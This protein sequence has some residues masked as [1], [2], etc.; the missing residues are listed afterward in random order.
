MASFHNLLSRELALFSVHFEHSL[1]LW[2]QQSFSGINSLS[3]ASTILPLL[4]GVSVAARR[5]SFTRRA[6]NWTD[7]PPLS[8]DNS[9][10]LHSGRDTNQK[11][12]RLH[13]GLSLF[14][15]NC[16]LGF[17]SVLSNFAQMVGREK[18]FTLSQ[19]RRRRRENIPQLVCP[20]ASPK[21]E[22]ARRILLLDYIWLHSLESCY[23]YYFSSYEIQSNG[24]KSRPLAPAHFFLQLTWRKLLNLSDAR[25][26]IIIIITVATITTSTRSPALHPFTCSLSAQMSLRLSLL[27]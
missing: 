16:S 11:L 15:G 9:P 23:Y 14:G 26:M 19:R 3:L 5:N 25:R 24:E 22:A 12:A 8:R 21:E 13:C 18:A 27:L 20:K 1:A 2:H 4:A 10:R 7:R 6:P 17:G